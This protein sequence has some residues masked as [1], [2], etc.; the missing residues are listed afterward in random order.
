MCGRKMLKIGEDFNMAVLFDL[1]GEQ[2]KTKAI[3][4]ALAE[5]V[6]HDAR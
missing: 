1:G 2:H 4:S 6:A 3:R 5:Y